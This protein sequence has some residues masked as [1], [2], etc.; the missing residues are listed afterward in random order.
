MTSAKSTAIFTRSCSLCDLIMEHNEMLHHEIYS[1]VS[2]LLKQRNDIGRYR[3]LDLGC[4]NAHY[5][6]PCL[7][8]SPPALY[9]G[10]DLSKAALAE[11]HSYLAGF[12]GLITLRHGDLLAAIES[13]DK[14]WDVI[15]SGLAV[16]HL[17]LD[18][19][20]RFFRAVGRCLA[21]N[22]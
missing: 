7:K 10:V 1:G 2:N 14:T 19:K 4:G 9:E 3:L 5:L 15:F 20:A 11:A 12:P 13:T 21:E 6:V 16:H 18:E 17:M 8:Q 22:G